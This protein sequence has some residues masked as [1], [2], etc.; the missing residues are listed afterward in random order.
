MTLSRRQLMM[1]TGKTAAAAALLLP[2][3]TLNRLWAATDSTVETASGKVRGRSIAGIHSFLGVRYG[4]STAGRNRFMPPQKPQPWS[5]IQDAFSYGSSAPQSNPA[6]RGAGILRGEIGQLLAGT[7]GPPPAESEDCLF[8]NVWTPGINDNAKRPVMFW[9]H[10]GGFTTGSD[11]SALYIGANLA[12][13]GDVV[14]VGINHRLGTLGF[15]HLG[16]LAGEQFV[17]SGNVGMLDAVAALE[18]VRDNIGRFGGDAS[19][20][21]IFGES[22]GGQKV[23][24]LLGSPPAKG[25]FQR[26]V[27]ESGPGP[28]MMERARATELAR[29]L[30][31][32]VGLDAKRTSDLQT[33]PLEK[34]MAAQF[35]VSAKLRGMAGI[36]DG[37]APVL[38]PTVLPAHPFY[39]HATRVSEDVPVII[40]NNRTEMTLFA[41]PAAFSLDENGLKTRVKNFVGD[42]ADDVI[43]VYRHAN[44]HATP[45]DLFFLIWTDD[46]TTVF[47]NNIAER[48]AALGKAPTYRYRFDW[49]TPVLGGRLKSPHTVEMPFVFDNTQ[50]APGLTGGASPE[51]VSL[52]ARVSEAWIAFAS[53]GDPNSK[54]SGLPP[55]PAYDSE[56]RA[57]MLF[58]NESKI[59]DDPSSEQRKAMDKILNP[60]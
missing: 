30:L 5:G 8:L 28:K 36:I 55:W 3:I 9:L 24:M 52:A 13:R 1:R 18:W 53:R 51:A 46:P 19:R 57:T 58:S 49:E 17:H 12:R 15:T 45:S 31:A 27:I 43:E 35:A 4:A 23:S 33:L 56:R 7:D 47:S 50:V 37:F 39:P 25:L 6:Q 32:E 21:M 41:D 20:V 38:D 42:R 11:S 14:V 54:K 2:D 26:A 29:M 10:G 34:I 22:G 59:V 60:A 40:G 44:P 16:D 48:R